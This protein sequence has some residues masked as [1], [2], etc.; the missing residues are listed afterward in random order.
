MP[1]PSVAWSWSPEFSPTFP[2]SSA[3]TPLFLSA[4]SSAKPPLL[5]D[6]TVAVSAVWEEGAGVEDD[7]RVL[8]S[9]SAPAVEEVEGGGGGGGGERD[10]DGEGGEEDEGGGGGEEGGDGLEGKLEVEIGEEE[11]EEEEEEEGAW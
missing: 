9:V 10:E 3:S 7:E 6:S 5:W 8:E 11:E 1:S 4:T 2:A